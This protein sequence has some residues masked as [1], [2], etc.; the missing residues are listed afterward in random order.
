MV[1]S[2]DLLDAHFVILCSRYTMQQIESTWDQ[3]KPWAEHIVEVA[4]QIKENTF[5]PMI[6]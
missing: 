6:H 3:V 4:E 2:K 1:K 5:R